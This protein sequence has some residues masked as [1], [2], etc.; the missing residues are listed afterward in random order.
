MFFKKGKIRS[1]PI[2][3]IDCDDVILNLVDSWLRHYNVAS[4][5]NLTKKDITEWNISKFVKPEYKEKIYE[6][7]TD[8][9]ISRNIFVGATVYEDAVRVTKWLQEYCDLYIVTATHPNNFAH[10]AEWIKY[11]F[12]HID[13]K[14]IVVLYDKH[15]FGADYIIDDKLETVDKFSGYGILF[16]QPWNKRFISIF[17][18]RVGN[19]RDIEKFFKREL[20][21]IGVL[22]Q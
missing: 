11:H 17:S 18:T 5:D 22:Q 2:I 8:P 6:Y 20:K 15:L 4:G 13:S 19:W 16:N 1:R 10:K 7:V 9:Q 12:P 3:A 21:K 14:N